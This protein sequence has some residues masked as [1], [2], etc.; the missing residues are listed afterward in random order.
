[1]VGLVFLVVWTDELIPSHT[2]LVDRKRSE[3][4][5]GVSVRLKQLLSGLG[6][7]VVSSLHHVI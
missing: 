6:C 4:E 7:L 1:M 2:V 3:L 5:D